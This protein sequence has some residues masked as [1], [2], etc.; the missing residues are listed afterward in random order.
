MLDQCG[1]ILAR[2]IIRAINAPRGLLTEFAAHSDEHS[3]VQPQEH[4]RSHER[5]GT[6]TS[7]RRRL[8]PFGRLPGAA[9]RAR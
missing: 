5:S 4:V 9:A 3:R 8:I 1:F 2:R 7:E 6:L